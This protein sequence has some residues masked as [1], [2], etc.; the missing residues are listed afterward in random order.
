MVLLSAA[1][2]CSGDYR[3]EIAVARVASSF[4]LTL[5]DDTLM[6]MHTAYDSGDATVSCSLELGQR[7]CDTLVQ[8]M[9]CLVM[10]YYMTSAKGFHTW[11]TCRRMCTADDL[12][13]YCRRLP[14]TCSTMT[15]LAP[16]QTLGAA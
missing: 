2:A 12:P 16:C 14:G 7:R 6:A 9:K 13:V 11:F 3:L 1:A 8:M 5:S 4:A 15:S 10:R